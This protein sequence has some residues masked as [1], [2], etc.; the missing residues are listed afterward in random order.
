MSRAD[1]YE[2]SANTQKAELGIAFAAKALK[3]LQEGQIIAGKTS[4]MYACRHAKPFRRSS[5]P[6]PAPSIFANHWLNNTTGKQVVYHTLQSTDDATSLE[7]L[8]AMDKSIAEHRESIAGLKTN[9]KLLR[10]NLASINA[11]MSTDE[12][13]SNVH[14]LEGERAELQARLA[15]LRQ[16]DVKPVSIE[17]KA[18]VDRLWGEWKKKAEARKK[19]AMEFWAM[20]ME[21]LPEGKTKAEVWVS[22]QRTSVCEIGALNTQWSRKSWALRAMSEVF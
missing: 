8:A 9:E 6:L 15:P 16:G 3:E 17:Q 21:A 11:I 22:A 7:D 14:S 18:E 2:P 13:R 20:G 4:G 1:R 12:L 10:S 5:Y 19:I